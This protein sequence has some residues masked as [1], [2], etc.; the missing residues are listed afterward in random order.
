MKQLR[1]KLKVAMLPIGGG[2]QELADRYDNFVRDTLADEGMSSPSENEEEE[3]CHAARAGLLIFL[4]RPLQPKFGPKTATGSKPSWVS[5]KWLF[6]T[7]LVPKQNL[8]AGYLDPK[9]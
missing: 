1:A 8:S 3:D 9:R 4:K 6:A 2:Y 5:L 7:R